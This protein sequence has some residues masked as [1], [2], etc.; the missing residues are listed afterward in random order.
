[1]AMELLGDT[2]RLTVLTG[3]GIAGVLAVLIWTRNLTRRVTYLRF[4]FQAVSLGA[5]FYMFTF[6]ELWLV[7]LLSIILIMTLVLGRFFCGWI[8]PFGFYMDLISQLRKVTKVRYRLIPEKLNGALNRLRYAILV[9]FLAISL[10]FVLPFLLS[11]I[12]S[13]QWSFLYF[14]IG[15]LKPISVL[16]GPLEPLIIPWKGVF[17]VS[18]IN[19][20][21]PYVTPIAFYSSVDFTGIGDLV[22]IN[23]LIFVALTL[24]ASF[25]VRRF[26][27]RFC[28]TGASL[29]VRFRG[30]SSAVLHI[31][32]DE[33]KCTKCGICKRVCPLQVTEVYE[34]KGGKITTSMCMLCLRC[35]EMCPYD[36][37]LKVKMG[38]KTVFKSR[39]WL[40]PSQTE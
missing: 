33:E 32:K 16:L 4:L 39:N 38:G 17:N 31:N 22:W 9:F 25:F 5:I 40:E 37:C 2:L 20:S 7:L 11:S 34:Q 35:V 1:M 30:K 18:G 26:W 3:L 15:P 10:F 24:V 21:Y 29:A 8:C 13:L 14:L 19:L 23:A 12:E 6:S 28:P 36:A 27:C